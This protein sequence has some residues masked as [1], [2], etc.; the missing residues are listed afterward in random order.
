MY[1]KC[2]PTV[3]EFRYDCSLYVISAVGV[4]KEG[5]DRPKD[6]GDEG[7]VVRVVHDLCRSFDIG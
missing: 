3:V 5:R 1:R 7:A 4:G 6:K 2:D